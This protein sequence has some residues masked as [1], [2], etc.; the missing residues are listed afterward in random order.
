[1]ATM[2]PDQVDVGVDVVR[3]LLRGQH[4]RWADLPIRPLSSGGTVNAVF[5]LG[6]EFSVRLP[7]TASGVDALVLEARWL[8]RIAPVV[9]LPTPTVVAIGEAGAG[10]PFPW[11]VHR[12]IDGVPLVE[13][14]LGD[15]R[16]IARDLAS[17]VL[18][19]R[20]A[21]LGDG[22][23][24]HRSSPLADSDAQVRAA[25]ESLRDTDE[26]LDIDRL[27]AVWT[28]CVS[29]STGPAPRCWIH[30]DLMPS[31][32]LGTDDHLSAVIDFGTVGLGDPAVDLIPA[33]NLLPPPAR[34]EFRQGVRVDDDTWA[35]GRGWALS[36]AAVQLPYYRTS[37]DVISNN[38]RWVFEQVLRD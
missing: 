37:N 10:Y 17:F 30:S 33:W 36:M 9:P 27:L 25:L 28:R 34:A 29:A 12:W 16:E 18:A 23:P 5:R 21:E 15:G 1:M 38:A 24:A 22:P 26:G 32:L 11:A 20:G 7:L 8:P 2:H 6:D 4:P 19:L 14:T 3:A 35:R 13:G 31:N